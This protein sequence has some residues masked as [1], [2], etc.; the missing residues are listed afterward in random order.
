ML[1]PTPIV[2]EVGE[3][4]TEERYPT[5]VVMVMVALV[6][7]VTP[8]REAVTVKR[9]TPVAGPAVKVVVDPVVGLTLPKVL[10]SIQT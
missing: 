3:M 2:M 8:F 1:F 6:H 4:L 9:T 10:L 7:L 5:E